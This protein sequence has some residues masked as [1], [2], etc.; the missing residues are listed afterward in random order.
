MSGHIHETLDARVHCHH[1]IPT[2]CMCGLSKENLRQKYLDPALVFVRGRDD[3]RI[4]HF[5]QPQYTQHG[6]EYRSNFKWPSK[7]Y[8]VI[9]YFP[10]K[11]PLRF[12]PKSEY[13][14]QLSI[15][16]VQPQSLEWSKGI[17]ERIFEK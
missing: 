12:E 8:P 4:I 1:N 10:P 7:K 13:D 6:S 14:K 11:S 2:H 5:I 3:N 16:K 17:A 9:P 15:P